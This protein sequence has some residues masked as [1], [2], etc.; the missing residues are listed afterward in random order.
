MANAEGHSL[1]ID[2]RQ[3]FRH[4]HGD[5]VF[6]FSQRASSWKFLLGQL[7]GGNCVVIVCFEDGKMYYVPDV[8]NVADLIPPKSATAD[9]LFGKMSRDSAEDLEKAKQIGRDWIKTTNVTRLSNAIPVGSIYKGGH[10][11]AEFVEYVLKTN[12]CLPQT[13]F[14]TLY[15]SFV[16]GQ[17]CLKWKA[18]V[19]PTEFHHIVH[20]SSHPFLA[21]L[22]HLTFAGML[23]K[24][25]STGEAVLVLQNQWQ[26]RL[27][28][29]VQQRFN[30]T[31]DFR[32]RRAEGGGFIVEIIRHHRS[33]EPLTTGPTSSVSENPFA[34]LLEESSAE[35]DDGAETME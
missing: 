6:N 33:K 23:K 31:I 13:V 19:K 32:L 3:T 25:T 10:L 12:L 27:D 4:L 9:I 30:K 20:P 1:N 16:F 8:E 14:Q 15:E 24:D 5:T 17:R 7:F 18:A 22:D 28:G 29:V 34:L 35:V 2:V 21:K 26:I 11:T